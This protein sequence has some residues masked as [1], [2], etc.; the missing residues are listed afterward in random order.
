[1]TKALGN[2][3]ESVFL[4]YIPQIEIYLFCLLLPSLDCFFINSCRT[5]PA[6]KSFAM[7][8]NRLIFSA[9]FDIIKP[10]G[11]NNDFDI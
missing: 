6:A 1:M 2:S 10:L 9:K 11:A 8:R 7:S 3:F 5:V 4:P